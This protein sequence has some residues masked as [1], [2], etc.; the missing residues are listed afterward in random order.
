MDAFILQSSETSYTNIVLFRMRI[1]NPCKRAH[2]GEICHDIYDLNTAI[3]F[4]GREWNLLP[5]DWVQ[6]TS[7]HA[8]G[9]VLSTAQ[10]NGTRL[11][12]LS[13][14]PLW[15]GMSSLSIPLTQ[16]LCSS[17]NIR[18]CSTST[19]RIARPIAPIVSG[20]TRHG[21][22]VINRANGASPIAR[23]NASAVTGKS[24]TNGFAHCL[25]SRT[26]LMLMRCWHGRPTG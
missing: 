3:P 16:E 2:E 1:T 10:R 21:N 7:I 22:V 13:I 25:N 18:I 24:F 19:R 6:L 5:S 8:F 14:A 15:V 4:A 23:A 26:F 11:V 9:H 12:Q 17:L 20:R